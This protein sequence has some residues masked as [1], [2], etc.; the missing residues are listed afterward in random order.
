MS[1]FTKD[2]WKSAVSELKKPRQL[3]LAALFVA[4]GIAISGFYI[5]V[6]ENLRVLFKFLATCVGASIY[7]P[8]M[9]LLT[10]AVSDTLGFLIWPQGGYF[11]GYLLS[12]IL[13]SVIYALF[14]YK[15][16]VTI[17]R[18]FFAKF[19]VNYGVN[20]LLGSVWSAVLY[21]K[22]YLYYLLTSLVKNTILL[23]VE[24]LLLGMLF[25]ALLPVL[26]RFGLVPS[27][28][29]ARL[30]ALRPG[31]G[32]FAVFG[33]DLLLAAGAAVYFGWI[34]AEVLLYW[35]AAGAAAAGVALLVT[36]AMKNRAYKAD[37]SGKNYG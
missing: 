13:G 9:A 2:Y 37:S 6:G 22:G 15:K 33:A 20:V 16:D 31:A 12:E 17:L 26:A 28:D 18:L 32:A 35:L 19:V 24:V 14:L 30:H 27:Y 7:G 34:K 4:L 21:S 8:V 25:A 11:P 10:G 5:P 36:G 3:V 23:P 1:I 29:A